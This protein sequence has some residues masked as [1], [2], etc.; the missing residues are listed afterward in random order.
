MRDARP[1]ARH[2]RMVSLDTVLGRTA[3][4]ARAQSR[5]ARKA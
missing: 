5:S 4:F 2:E 1:L 3:Q